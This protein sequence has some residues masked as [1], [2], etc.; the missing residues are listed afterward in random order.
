MN[1]IELED[2]GFGYPG[3]PLLFDHLNLT[4]EPG[5][6][7]GLSGP[8]GSGKSTLLSLLAGWAKPSRGKISKPTGRIQWVFQ[9]PHGVARRSVLDHVSLPLLA[10]GH[11]RTVADLQAS[12]LL[13]EFGLKHLAT[14]EF[15]SLSGGEA[16]RLMLARGLA[17]H[18]ALL[19]VDE[20]TAQLDRHSAKIVS[21]HL[22]ALAGTGAIVVIASHDHDTLIE[23]SQIIDLE[24][25]AEVADALA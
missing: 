13:D 7:Y 18:P 22:G 6:V 16:Q 12:V 1:D 9:N 15:S 20:P 4:L 19:L 3:K 17:A 5:Q 14:S 10:A 11:S 24:Q 23:C 2:L 8:S 25:Y 21:A